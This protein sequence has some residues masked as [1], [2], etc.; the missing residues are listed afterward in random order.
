MVQKTWQKVKK[1]SEVKFTVARNSVFKISS[2]LKFGVNM[3]TFPV[4][5]PYPCFFL[6]NLLTRSGNPLAVL[7]FGVHVYTCIWERYFESRVEGKR[8]HALAHYKIIN[9]LRPVSSVLIRNW[10]ILIFHQ[11]QFLQS[12]FVVF[13]ASWV[14][15]FNCLW[16]V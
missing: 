2:E 1:N 15:K 13:G 9:F 12:F 8:M 14:T 3:F 5:L 10:G 6:S 11:Y 4:L 7:C 16:C